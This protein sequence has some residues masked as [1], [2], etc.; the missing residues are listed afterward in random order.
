M[1]PSGLTFAL[2]SLLTPHHT[3]IE[4]NAA[5]YFKINI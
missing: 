4:L 3:N 5:E 1:T 2:N